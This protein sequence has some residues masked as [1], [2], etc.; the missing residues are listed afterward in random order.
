[1]DRLIRKAMH[2][3]WLWRMRRKAPQFVKDA[4]KAIAEGRQ[5]HGKVK[6]TQA[7]LQAQMTQTLRGGF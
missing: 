6:A 5:R 7:S 3:W 1:M 2:E 4:R